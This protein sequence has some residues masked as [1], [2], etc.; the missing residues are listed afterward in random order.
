MLPSLSECSF[1]LKWHS[2]IYCILLL[3]YAPLMPSVQTRKFASFSNTA[4][5]CP[6]LCCEGIHKTYCI[7]G[8]SLLRDRVWHSTWCFMWSPFR[9]SLLARVCLS[10]LPIYLWYTQPSAYMGA[11]FLDTIDNACYDLLEGY[12]Y[13]PGMP[14]C[15]QGHACW[16]VCSYV[17]R[18]LEECSDTVLNR[19]G[20][21]AH[22]SGYTMHYC[23]VYAMYPIVLPA[24]YLLPACVYAYLQ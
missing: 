12:A 3:G 1:S 10:L 17:W 11:P 24:D 5:C 9:V 14:T 22:S 2:T 21:R 8:C 7:H 16:M 18:T 4:W 6:P 19:L 23:S 15:L 13:L 20:M